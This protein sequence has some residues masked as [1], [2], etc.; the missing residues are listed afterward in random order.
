MS[1]PQKPDSPA[2]SISLSQAPQLFLVVLGGRLPGVHIELHDVRFVVGQTLE[3]TLP[4]LRRQWFGRRRGLHID[5]WMVVRQVGAFAVELRRDPSDAP[6]RLWFVN[7]GGYRADQLAEE[8]AFGLVVATTSAGAKR[9]ALAGWLSEHLRRHK[10]D[11]HPLD[12]L[13]DPE[14]SEA[15]DDCVALERV[16]GWRVHLRPVPESP[17]PQRPDWFGY[18]PI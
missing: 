17:P 7:V 12:A 13:A 14:A 1:P 3:D 9:Q 5:S 10:D 11:L 15:V 16:E 2:P 6:E 4:A 18:R 8:H